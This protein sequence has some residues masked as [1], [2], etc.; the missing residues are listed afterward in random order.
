MP[1]DPSVA[2]SCR[3]RRR[4]RGGPCGGDRR[5]PVHAVHWPVDTVRSDLADRRPEDRSSTASTWSSTSPPAAR[6]PPRSTRPRRPPRPRV[7]DA[8]AAAASTRLV[9]VTSALV[10]GAWAN[11]PVPLTEDAPLRPNPDFAVAVGA[12]R[13][14]ALGR[15]VARRPPGADGRHPAPGG[16]VAEGPGG[17]PGCWAGAASRW[18]RRPAGPV[19]PPRRPRRRRGLPVGPPRRPANVA[20]DGWIAGDRPRPRRR[21]PRLAC[22]SGWPP[23]GRLALAAGTRPRRRACCPGPCTPGSWPPTACGPRLDGARPTRRPSSPATGRCRGPRSAPAPPGAHPRRRRS[24]PSCRCGLGAAV[25]VRRL[26][27]AQLPKGTTRRRR[28][29][30][31]ILRSGA[32]RG[33]GFRGAPLEVMGSASGTSCLTRQIPEPIA[34]PWFGRRRRDLSPAMGVSPLRYGRSPTLTVGFAVIAV[35]PVADGD[36]VAGLV[37]AHL[38]RQAGHR[39]DGLAVDLG[40]DVVAPDAGPVGGAALGRPR[41]P[42]PR[43]PRPS[44]RRRRWRG[45]CPRCRASRAGPCPRR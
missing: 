44:R 31:H 19:R 39:L 3:W 34:S 7:L 11:N 40:D 32:P 5:R 10:Y 29:L 2:G 41:G 37:L 23:S 45:R 43:R 9:V 20:P 21:P 42:W 6:S 28:A 16:A 33:N 26:R 22:P 4:P 15:R 25:G 18:R 13:G 27:L 36:L 8:A 1:R 17:W 35:A 38:H 12:G 30:T 14:R 24:P